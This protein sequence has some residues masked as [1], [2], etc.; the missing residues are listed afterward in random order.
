[1]GSLFSVPSH[2]EPMTS[3]CQV[4]SL[5]SQKCMRKYDFDR[6]QYRKH[7][8]ASFQAYRDCKA[9]WQ[10]MKSRALQNEADQQRKRKLQP[11]EPVN[12]ARPE[13]SAS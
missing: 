3:Y 11:H 5:A 4:E 1:M 7:C 2:L 6:E 8:V 13:A 12:E 10:E 9:R